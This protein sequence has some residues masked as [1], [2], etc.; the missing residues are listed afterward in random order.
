MKIQS[1]KLTILDIARAAN[2]SKTTI[3]RYINGKYEYMSGETKKRIEQVIEE[4]QYRPNNIARSLKSQ[5]SKLVGALVADIGS[6]F[7]SILVK[8]IGD[9]C[10]E[11]GYNLIIV[12]TDDNVEKENEYILSLLDQRVEGIVINTVDMNNKFLIETSKSG[13]PVVLADRELGCGKL[14][15]VVTDN[16][17][18]TSNAINHLIEVGYKNIAVFTQNPDRITTRRGR[19]EAFLDVCKS[20]MG[21]DASDMVYVIDTNDKK[22]V[23]RSISHLIGKSQGNPPAIFAVNGVT[24]LSVL[25]A[26][27][28]LHLKMP[29]DIGVCGYDDWGWAELVPPGITTL[30]QS[31]Y[32]MGVAATKM[33][34]ER[35]NHRDLELQR[36]VLQ[37]D[38]VLR[39]STRL[40]P[41]A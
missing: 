10:K 30:A 25:N 41:G 2:V 23:V 16:A 11:N 26:V 12:N 35:I 29:D 3:S 21:I 33:L 28:T 38:L 34:L 39:G 15:A 6:Q 18:A 40:K 5:R 14:D 24:L 1:N 13:L 36:L 27:N 7:S 32:D 17:G 31:T 19:I 8:G 4:A 9:V 20:R 37:T 22:S